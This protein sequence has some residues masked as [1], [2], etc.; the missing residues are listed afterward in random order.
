MSEFIIP[1]VDIGPYLQYPTSKEAEVVMGKIYQACITSG[2]FQLVGHPIPSSLQE[3]V[4]EGAQALFALPMHE[5][6]TLVSKAGGLGNQGYEIIGAQALQKNTL[7]DLKE[8][9]FVG[10]EFTPSVI[11]SNPSIFAP[12]VW[13]TALPSTSITPAS[14]KSTMLEYQSRCVDLTKVLLSLLARVLPY[15]PHIFETFSAD[16][17]LAVIRLLHY[18]PQ[19]CTD[20]RQLG[21]GAHT[22]FGALTL[23]L[24]DGE[25]AGLEVLDSDGEWQA[26]PPVKHALVVN[27]GDMLHRWTNG[28]FKSS[29]H[30]VI[31]RSGRDRY[32][33][34]FFY[35]GNPDCR[36]VPFEVAAKTGDGNPLY[37]D[38]ITVADHMKE[39]YAATVL[40]KSE[41]TAS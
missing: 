40:K 15:G 29:V 20:P 24:Q 18:P 2:F 30:R 4:F 21:A 35:D 17:S 33:V 22:D 23:L 13:P 12:N 39:R 38:Y 11:A 10:E 41:A 6:E 16:P 14:F 31:N 28:R 36:L 34:P 26:V 25:N 9:F 7:P 27:V 3:K 1:T 8:G 32:S 5:K 19:D 37:Q